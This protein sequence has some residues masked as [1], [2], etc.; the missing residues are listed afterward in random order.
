VK[1]PGA[2]GQNLLLIHRRPQGCWGLRERC[3]YP[4]G[5]VS[6]VISGGLDASGHWRG[7]ARPPHFKLKFQMGFI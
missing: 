3:F 4:D 6:R 2:K 7:H 1:G 5:V